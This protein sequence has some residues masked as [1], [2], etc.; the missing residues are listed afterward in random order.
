[1]YSKFILELRFENLLRISRQVDLYDEDNLPEDVGEVLKIR[2]CPGRL[3]DFVRRA[4]NCIHS[5]WNL[6]ANDKYAKPFGVFYSLED[7]KAFHGD[8]ALCAWELH[9]RLSNGLKSQ[10]LVTGS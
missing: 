5:R 1:M 10:K 6:D 7:M 9:E 4:R 3:G 8:F 2:G